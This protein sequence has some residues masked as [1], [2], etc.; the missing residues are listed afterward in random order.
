MN[1]KNQIWFQN[2]SYGTTDVIFD[3]LEPNYGIDV[4]LIKYGATRF[5]FSDVL[6]AMRKKS[7]E[8]YDVLFKKLNLLGL[9]SLDVILHN[10]INR[11]SDLWFFTYQS[12]DS[13]L[14]LDLIV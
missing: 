9:S 14:I 8:P 7:S 3:T 4:D 13:I 5:D 10:L 2:P 1:P 12:P 6:F 11:K